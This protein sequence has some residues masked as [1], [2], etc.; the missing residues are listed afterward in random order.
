[1]IQAAA[2]SLRAR[3]VS[4][5]ELTKAA[6]ERIDRLNPL[7]RAFISVT[8]GQAM[9]EAREAWAALSRERADLPELAAF[10]R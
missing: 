5:E 1:M 7:L 2:E 8:P 10:A 9:Q 3:R 6:I 4:A